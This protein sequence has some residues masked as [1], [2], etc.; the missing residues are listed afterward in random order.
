MSPFIR[1]R[2]CLKHGMNR[3]PST[4]LKL[5]SEA[6]SSGTEQRSDLKNQKLVGSILF[7]AGSCVSSLILVSG[8]NRF[9]ALNGRLVRSQLDTFGTSFGPTLTLSGR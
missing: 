5:K 3:L 9:R 2:R 8:L 6:L 7:Q 4:L 1:L